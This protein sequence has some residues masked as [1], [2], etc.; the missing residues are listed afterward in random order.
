MLSNKCHIRGVAAQQVG[1]EETVG[2]LLKE[3]SMAEGSSPTVRRRQLGME[4]RRLRDA[5]GKGQQEA[6][7]WLD[8]AATAISKMET[9]KQRVTSAYLRALL[10]LYGVGSPHSEALERLRRESS[11][12]GWWAAYGDTVPHWFADYVGMEA[13]AAEAWTYESEFIP[14]LLQTP[15]YTEAISVAL[16]P[17]RTQE[18]T[19]RVVQLRAERQKRLAS[20]EPIILRAVI[21]EAAL[22]REVGSAQVMSAQAARIIEVVTNLPN[23]TVQIL[24]F[25][26]GAH[27]GM[28][29]PFTALRFPQE[30][31]NTVYLELYGAAYY[32]EAPAEIERYAKRF[33]EIASLALD[34]ERTVE[35]LTQVAEERR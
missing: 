3:G 6:G 17:T 11:Q 2:Y 28:R 13:A 31:M 14:G 1:E 35:L 8:I 4:L 29:G 10:Q 16:N 23:V 32:V 30:P 24:P 22:R 15:Q 18:E 5:A 33:E 21:N 26:A 9:G 20:D 19:Q 25:S 27:R 34:A 12:R 7:D